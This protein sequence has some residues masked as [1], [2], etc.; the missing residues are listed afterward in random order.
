MSRKPSSPEILAELWDAYCTRHHAKHGKKPSK[1]QFCGYLDWDPSALAKW[2]TR[3]A[4]NNRRIPVDRIPQLAEALMLSKKEADR[5]MAARVREMSAADPSV[6]EAMR[7][8]IATAKHA[9]AQRHRLEPD[10]RRLLVAFRTAVTF[11]PRWLY[12]DREEEDVLLAQMQVLLE[13]AEEL[14]AEEATNQTDDHIDLRD[15]TQALLEKM[16]AQATASRA[17]EF[18][19]AKRRARKMR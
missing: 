17:F 3:D 4:P 6:R 12:G 10:E 18:A 14:H 2:M 1:R 15:R 16:R 13:R 7:W 5:L 19:E 9:E 8:A 11:Y